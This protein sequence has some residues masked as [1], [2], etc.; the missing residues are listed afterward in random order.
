MASIPEDHAAPR[1][2]KNDIYRQEILRARAMTPEQRMAE[3]FELSDQQ[4][5]RMLAAAMRRL[6]TQDEKAGWKE[7]ARWMRAVD[8]IREHGLY[9]SEKPAHL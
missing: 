8:A 6:G 2:L 4:F 3:V 5:A 7:V 9:T 1:A